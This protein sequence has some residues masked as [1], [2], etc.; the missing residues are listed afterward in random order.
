[1]SNQVTSDILQYLITALTF[2][3]PLYELLISNNE[4]KWYKKITR[5]GYF[6]LFI[7]ALMVINLI[8]LN[9][10]ENDNNQKDNGL[11]EEINT[12]KNKIIT[13]QD[14]L[15]GQRKI[16]SDVD[17]ILKEVYNLSID[18]LTKGTST[19]IINNSYSNGTVICPVQ[20]FL[21]VNPSN[22]TQQLCNGDKIPLEY[23][24]NQDGLSFTIPYMINK[25]FAGAFSM[26]NQS[27]TG[28]E[29][30]KKTGTFNLAPSGITGSFQGN[31][32]IFIEFNANLPLKQQ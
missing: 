10:V 28:V 22:K 7:E 26:N 3:F 1:M 30:N 25:D 23:I 32:D 12:S 8:Y 27:L 31:N 19:T 6:V 17:H 9:R 13:L 11:R 14:S 21:K 15:N 29:Y 20:V 5:T 2:V 16:L 18:K 4:R 24:V